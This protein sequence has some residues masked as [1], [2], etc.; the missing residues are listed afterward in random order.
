MPAG[1][2]CH[3]VGKALRNVCYCAVTYMRFIGRL[4]ISVDVFLNLLVKFYLNN[5]VILHPLSPHIRRSYTHKMA[6]VS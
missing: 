5:T 3:L 6:S 1:F 2:R 4:M